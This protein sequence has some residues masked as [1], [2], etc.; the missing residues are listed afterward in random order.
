MT[1]PVDR[2]PA[3][4]DDHEDDD[5]ETAFWLSVTGLR[6]SLAEAEADVAAGRTYGEDEIRARYAPWRRS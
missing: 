6:E 1:G 4:D 2:S 3:D 5:G